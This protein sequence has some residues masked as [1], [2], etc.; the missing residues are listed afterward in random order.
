M[1][2]AKIKPIP[3][4]TQNEAKQLKERLLAFFKDYAV[5]EL[6]VPIEEDCQTLMVY[7]VEGITASFYCWETNDQTTIHN[8][9]VQLASENPVTNLATKVRN[10]SSKL[11]IE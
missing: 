6:E 1:Y 3:S 2:K 11:K 7:H 8:F 4:L 9:Q 10:L 5:E